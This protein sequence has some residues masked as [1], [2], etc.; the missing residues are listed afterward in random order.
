MCWL[1]AMARHLA[2][3]RLR[4]RPQALGSGGPD[5]VADTPLRAQTR[6]TVTGEARRMA[7][8]LAALAPARAAALRS[9][10]LDGASHLRLAQDHAVP[11]NTMRTWLRLSLLKLKECLER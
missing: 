6:L 10:Y 2:I 1:I 4:A 7:D 9:A 8:C 3:D 11:P 5:R